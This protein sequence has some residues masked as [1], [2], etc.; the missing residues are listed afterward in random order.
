MLYT[1]SQWGWASF[2]WAFQPFFT[3]VTTFI[4]VPYLTNTVLVGTWVDSTTAAQS[5]WG[6]IMGVLYVGVAI[7]TIIA[8]FV[9][10]VSGGLKR[11]TLL[12]SLLWMVFCASIWLL[13]MAMSPVWWAMLM[14]GA[15]CMATLCAEVAI[16]F[17]NSMLAYV[18]EKKRVGGLS[19]FAYGMSYVG[20]IISLGIFFVLFMLPETP[21]L[22]LNKQAFEP[23]RFSTMLAAIWFAV[24]IIP[25]VVYTKEVILMRTMGFTDAIK[26]GVHNAQDTIK[27]IRQY[28]NIWRFLLARMVYNNGILA[29]I[30][31]A[32]I[33]ASASFGWSTMEL[34]YFAILLNVI[35]FIGAFLGGYFDDKI[36][37]KRVIQSA[38]GFFIIGL[39]G[40]LSID[41]T[42]AFFGLWDFGEGTQGFLS[43][44]PQ[45]I[46]LCF[47]VLLGLGLA[48]SQSASRT[49][50]IRI[51]PKDKI[52]T[53]FGIYGFMGNVTYFVLPFLI[54]GVTH[55]TDSRRW[56]IF[57]IVIFFA[58]GLW[59]LKPV[60]EKNV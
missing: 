39:V 56:G 28:P 41:N 31:F 20:G 51:T 18:I 48:P 33:Y 34:G 25:F 23:E 24:F 43:S 60:Q 30:A 42:S 16:I 35:A 26:S 45:L 58:I 54:G 55:I 59:I 49:L 15:F 57:V 32:G 46:F 50:M 2:D 13:P 7:A 5:L 36:G 12:A 52:A 19:G 6:V 38:I 14:V 11:K 8:G 1:K 47:G 9:A 44:P 4:F 3:V 21:A 40:G 53:Y 10:N 22:G 17:N 27:D 37:A 29:V